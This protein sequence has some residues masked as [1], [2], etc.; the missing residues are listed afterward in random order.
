MNNIFI[1]QKDGL[2]YERSDSG[3]FNKIP[4]KMTEHPELECFRKA[5]GVMMMTSRSRGE[6]AT[7]ANPT[8]GKSHT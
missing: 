5:D 6:L 2:L 3:W 8:P 4:Q 7:P 1:N